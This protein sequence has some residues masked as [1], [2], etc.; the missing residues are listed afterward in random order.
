[1]NDALANLFDNALEFLRTAIAEFDDNPKMSLIHF[2]TGVELVFKS[3][4]LAEHW[5]L[6][7]ANRREPDVS[8][9]KSG[10]LCTP[11]RTDMFLSGMID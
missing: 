9:S 2:N 5:T 7:V 1:M 11:D 3:Q 8:E 10:R 6:V 4:L